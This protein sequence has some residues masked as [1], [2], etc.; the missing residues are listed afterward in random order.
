MRRF[1]V[2]EVVGDRIA[3]ANMSQGQL[4]RRLRITTGYASQLLSGKRCPSAEVRRLM[5]QIPALEDAEFDDLF[6]PVL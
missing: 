2:R 3:R 1:R 6:E 5:M 4:A